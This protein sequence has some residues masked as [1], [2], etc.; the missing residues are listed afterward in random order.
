MPE[1]TMSSSQGKLCL[2]NKLAWLR[3]IFILA[4]ISGLIPLSAYQRV[5][6]SKTLSIYAEQ[7]IS[8]SMR[9]I[10]T[11]LEERIGNLQMKLG[12]YPSTVAAIYIVSGEA[13]YQK[14]SLGK[15]EIVEF[16]DAFYSGSEGRIYIRS[17]DQ[18]QENYLK[19]LMHEYIHWY[20]EQLFIGTP[21]WFHEGMATY[22]SGQL[23]YDRYLLYI[24]ESFLGKS[25]DLYRMSYRYPAVQEDWPHFYLS[26][27]MALRFM[28]EKHP[29]AWLRFWDTV[30][31]SHRQGYKIRFNQAFISS[32]GISLYDF[33]HQFERYS[34]KQGYLYLAV[35]LNSLIFLS[36][37]FIMLIVARKRK[38][39]MQ[40]LPDWEIEVEAQDPASEANVNLADE[41]EE[42]QP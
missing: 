35:A 10:A 1:T 24:R 17:G 4:L 3:I 15:A 2:L 40:M 31:S 29:Q 9:K 28:E 11:A 27:A 34:R 38:R 33:N 21:L 14:L 32:Y 6:S 20:L 12:I 22:H 5:Y 23:G 37:P 30:A 26:S 19:I 13:E 16:S 41:D 36:L 7:E 39:R 42:P 18:V 8:P 25:G